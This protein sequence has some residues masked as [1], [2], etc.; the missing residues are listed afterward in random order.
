MSQSLSISPALDPEHLLP[1][2]AELADTAC[3][4]S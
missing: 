2:A 3:G 4:P 1:S